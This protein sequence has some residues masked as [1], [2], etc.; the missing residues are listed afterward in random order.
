[1]PSVPTPP[2]CSCTHSVNPR[3]HSALR[4]PVRA[5]A[6]AFASHRTCTR[7]VS[8]CVCTVSN[9]VRINTLCTDQSSNMSVFNTQ[10][11]IT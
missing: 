10:H 3:G 6:S 2:G 8:K 11:N 7:L 5:P 1:M 9:C 4:L